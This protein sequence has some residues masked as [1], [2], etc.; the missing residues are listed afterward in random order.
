M[1]AA[2]AGPAECT[3]GH[4]PPPPPAPPRPRHLPWPLAG[5][6]PY[7]SYRSS[8]IISITNDFKK[9]C[10]AFLRKKQKHTRRADHYLFTI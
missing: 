7:L 9:S 8:P 2:A 5:H 10:N 6:P 1:G 3:E 4:P